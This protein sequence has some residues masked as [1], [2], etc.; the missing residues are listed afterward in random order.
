[1]KLTTKKW[2]LDKIIAPLIVAVFT[3]LITAGSVLTIIN[4]TDKNLV[5]EVAQQNKEIID[6]LIKMTQDEKKS[7]FVIYPCKYSENPVSTN[8]Q[9]F[10]EYMR[11]REEFRYCS[12]YYENKKTEKNESKK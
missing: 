1:M 2:W 9:L 8:G 10:S 6:L 11:I 4:F 3:S 7:N 5:N 12:G